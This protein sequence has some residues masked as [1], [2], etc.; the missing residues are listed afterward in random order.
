[1]LK[2]VIIALF[3]SLTGGIFSI[4][5]KNDTLQFP[6][7][8]QVYQSLYQS[9][10]TEIETTPTLSFIQKQKMDDKSK[11]LIKK[12]WEFSGGVKS[13]EESRY[14][15]F[16]FNVERDN[17]ISS[18]RHHWWDRYTGDYRLEYERNKD[19]VLVLFNVNSK[20]GSVWKNGQLIIND[21]TAQTF[22]QNAYTAFINDTYWL[23]AHLKLEDPGVNVTFSGTEE[24]DNKNHSILHVSFGDSVGLTPGDQY[25]FYVSDEGKVSRWK[26]LLQGRST[27]SELNWNDY[28]VVGKLQVS[29]TK[30]SLDGK[31]SI[32]FTNVNISKDIQHDIFTHPFKK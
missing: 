27:S 22:I 1:M 12:I 28:Q 17:K 14:F 18:S 31:F 26:Y 29:L 11:Q 3:L 4:S 30:S 7:S 2:I 8:K 16:T 10:L 19:T 6:E 24:I 32:K 25:W 5:E 13:W 9:N 15:Q 21:S 20:S 23:V